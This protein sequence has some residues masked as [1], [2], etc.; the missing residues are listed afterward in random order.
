MEGDELKGLVGTA[1]L[2]EIMARDFGIDKPQYA[3][4]RLARL[5][6]IPAAPVSRAYVFKR[7]DL[8]AIAEGSKDKRT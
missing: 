3:W 4:Q 7:E 6:R 8:Q 2:R 1:E 5:G